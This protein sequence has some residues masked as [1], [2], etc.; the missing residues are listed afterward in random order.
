MTPYF[1]AGIL[2]LLHYWNSSPNFFKKLFEG[3]IIR[4]LRKCF[5][6]ILF[7]TIILQKQRLIN[8]SPWIM[9]QEM[10]QPIRSSVFYV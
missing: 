8:F 5:F 9:N 10:P 7:W 2:S 6:L 3:F 1:E 4:F